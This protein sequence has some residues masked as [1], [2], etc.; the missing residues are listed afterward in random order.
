MKGKLGIGLAVAAI[1]LCVVTLARSQN[2]PPETPGRYQ[3]TSAH[4]QVVSTT[5]PPMD[6]YTIV[7]IDTA[8]GTVWQYAVT[9]DLSGHVTQQ[10][11]RL[12]D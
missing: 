10:W 5:G 6:V 7:K 2:S 11:I 8:T 3:I 1:L 9:K 12:P 4:I